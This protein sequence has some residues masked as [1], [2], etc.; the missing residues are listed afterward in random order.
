MR[1][2]QGSTLFTVLLSSLALGVL[3]AQETEIRLVVK[4]LRGQGMLYVAVYDSQEGFKAEK[5]FT[6]LVLE[7]RG[8]TIQT[9]LRL[10]EGYYVFSMFQ[11]INGNGILDKGFMGIPKEPIG[12]SRF[13]KMGIPGS[14]DKHK[15]WLGSA[16][17]AVTITLISF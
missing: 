5:P 9:S 6:S 11:D 2:W 1:L 17:D 8:D 12:L 10:P 13:E 14:F 4:G 7:P 16:A 15:I 3:G